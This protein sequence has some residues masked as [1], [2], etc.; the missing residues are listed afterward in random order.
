MSGL[1]PRPVDLA[2]P[3]AGR[4][5]GHRRR[6]T[7]PATDPLGAYAEARV[8]RSARLIPPLAP[9]RGGTQLG[10]PARVGVRQRRRRRPWPTAGDGLA[11][12]GRVGFRS[13]PRGV[14]SCAAARA[15]GLRGVGS[16]RTRRRT[17]VKVWSSKC[18]MFGGD[19]PRGSRSRARPTS[20]VVCR[21]RVQRW[22]GEP[23]DGAD[24]EVVRRLVQEE[25]V[26]FL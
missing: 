24:V 26:G 12:G 11:R 16:P 14:S 1:A 9:R 18:T 6:R 10:G 15:V 20:T 7:P 8:P 23:V 21:Q 17:S 19:G 2:T 25:E 22:R 13:R 3:P 4:P 5:G